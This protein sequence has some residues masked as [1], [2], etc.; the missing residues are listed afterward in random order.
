[1]KQL[2]AQ[3]S[4]LAAVQTDLNEQVFISLWPVKLV[5]AFELVIQGKKPLIAVF[6]LF[7]PSVWISC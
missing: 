3:S 7:E 6:N 1:M 5:K 2:S 4:N